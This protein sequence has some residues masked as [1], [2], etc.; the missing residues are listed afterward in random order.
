MPIKSLSKM[1]RED[2]EEDENSE[3]M[4]MDKENN[5]KERKEIN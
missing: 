1:K 5:N 2:V 4:P 3:E